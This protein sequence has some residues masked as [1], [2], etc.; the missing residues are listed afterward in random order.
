M[1]HRQAAKP[2]E[3]IELHDAVRR[4]IVARQPEAASA[5][6][7]RLLAASRERMLRYTIT[8]KASG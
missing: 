7:T 2:S 8:A 3:D 5:S 4:Q 6:M 1:L